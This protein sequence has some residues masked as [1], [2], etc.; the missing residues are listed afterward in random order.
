M[1]KEEM[2]MIKED[3][4]KYKV[5]TENDFTKY[6]FN[7]FP[8]KTVSFYH[9]YLT[10]LYRN[11]ILYRYDS[12]LLKPCGNRKDFIFSQNIDDN[13]KKILLDI[14]PSIDISIWQLSDLYR[15]MSLR[16][17]V[18]IIFVE[19]YYY[20]VDVVTNLLID[21]GKKVVLEDDYDIY[22]KYNR[23]DELYVVRKINEDSPIAKKNEYSKSKECKKSIIVSPKI[24]KVLVD[25]IGDDIFD[26]IL[27]DETFMIL[28]ELLKQYKINMATVK[29]YATKKHRWAGIK[30]AIESTGF[31]IEQGEFR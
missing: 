15:F 16:S 5:I 10:D 24:E 30:F 18:N 28:C 3:L 22:V 23:V 4:K 13:I 29:R 6:F 7:K 12:D 27:S 14:D 26:T 31:N 20:A 8:K 2:L 1:K 11:N 19:T 17:F 9:Y 25:I 21:C